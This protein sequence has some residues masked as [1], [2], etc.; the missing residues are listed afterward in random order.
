M[1]FRNLW[2]L[3]HHLYHHNCT[4]RRASRVA[5]VGIPRSLRLCQLLLR[6]CRDVLSIERPP[7]VRFRKVLRCMSDL[8]TIALSVRACPQVV[9]PHVIIYKLILL[10]LKC[11]RSRESPRSS[12]ESTTPLMTRRGQTISG[13]SSKERSTTCLLSIRSTLAAT[14]SLSSMLEKMPPRYSKM[15]D[16]H[17][18]PKRKWSSTSSATTLSRD[19]S[20]PFKRSQITTNQETC[21]YLS[22]TRYMMFLTSNIQVRRHF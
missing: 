16:T 13:S 9:F 3:L 8:G 19:N 6:L 11:L 5:E 15:L 4:K 18:Q 20:R 7:E 2:L 17:S 10:Y 14:I 12:F 22:T 21:G 1:A